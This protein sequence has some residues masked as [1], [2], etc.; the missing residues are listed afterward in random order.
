MVPYGR[1]VEKVECANHMVKCY[2]NR[3]HQLRADK[4]QLA[5]HPQEMKLLTASIPRLTTGARAAIRQAG[6]HHD[7]ALLREDLRN[8][9]R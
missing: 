1:L 8:G 3:L 4:V 5:K 6:E 9:P 2:T 7:V